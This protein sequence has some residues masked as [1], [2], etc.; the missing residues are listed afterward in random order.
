MRLL[1]ALLLLAALLALGPAPAPP[2]ALSPAASDTLRLSVRSGEPLLALLPVESEDE[3]R[4]LRLPALSWLVGP[5]LYW[6][7]ILGEE[8][9]ETILL[10]RRR[11]GAVRDTLVVRVDVLP[12]DAAP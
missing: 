6:R 2:G 12:A 9:F 1:P 10:E 8:G 3:L 5:S 4:P 11:D 7:T